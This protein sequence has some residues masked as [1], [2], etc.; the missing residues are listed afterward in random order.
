MAVIM[1]CPT[2]STDP[3]VNPG[4]CA[5]C[6]DADVRKGRGEPPRYIEASRWQRAPDHIPVDWESM[7]IQALIAHFD[8]ARRTHG[9]PQRTVEALM[10]GL[11]ER[12]TKALEEPATKRRLPELSDRQLI[13][14]GDRLQKLKPEIARAWSPEGIKLLLQAR[15]R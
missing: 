10:L 9:A 1:T 4:F 14:I 12:G 7:S 13:E 6:R 5:L 8:R 2:C 15:G 11:R 3:C